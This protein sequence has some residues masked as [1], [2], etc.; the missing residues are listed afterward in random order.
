MAIVSRPLAGALIVACA[1]VMSSNGQEPGWIQLFDGKTVNGWTAVGGIN[2]TVVDGAISATPAA[3]PGSPTADAKQTWPQGFL[4]SVPTFADFEMTAEF[5]SEQDTNSGLFIRCAEPANPGSLGSCYEINISDPH[6]TSPTGSI[7]GVHSTLPKRIPSAGKWSRFD[8]LA[9]GPHIVVK[10]NGETATDVRD[11]KLREG[12]LGLQAGGPTGSGPV[13]F[14]NLRIRPLR[15]TPRQ[16]AAQSPGAAAVPQV[17]RADFERWKKEHSNWG[18]WGIDD[19][20]GALNLITPAKRRQAAA[21]VKEGVSVSLSRVADTEKAIDN[22]D[23]FEH[24]MIE[25]GADRMGVVPHGVAHTHLDSLAHIN[26]NGVF[27]NG[28]KPDAASVMKRGHTR[29]SIINLKNGIFTRGVLVD[30]PR[31]KGV[32]YLEPGTPIYAQDIEAWEK[33]AGVKIG[34]GDAVFLRT[35]RWA[36]RAALGPFDTNRTARRSGPSASMIPWL[37]QRDIALLGGDVPPSVAPSDVEGETGAVHDFAL[38]YL[39]VHIFD[40]CDLE[41][42]AEAAQARKRWDFLLTVAP[43]VIQ[44]GTGSPVNPI[45]TF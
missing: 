35:G 27:Y 15:P 34:P 11:E 2:W 29:N 5:W 25:I 17:S 14:R 22:P 1:S 20:L 3:Q 10:V 39:G 6:A 31:L 24:N 9:D 26:Y 13:K 38:V 19:Q 40:N 32:P 23:P 21:L 8:V 45:A 12:A 41:A 33:M 30:L 36:R 43:L 44:G 42:L 16:A 28:Y 18:R 7:V 37:K 4:R